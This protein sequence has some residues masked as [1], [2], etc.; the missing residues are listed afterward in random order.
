MSSLFLM[1]FLTENGF[2]KALLEPDERK[3]LTV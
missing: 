3:N 2:A 1:P